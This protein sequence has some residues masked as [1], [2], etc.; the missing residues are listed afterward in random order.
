MYTHMYIPVG[1]QTCWS[2]GSA[3]FCDIMR[4]ILVIP[5]RHFGTTYRSHLEGSMILGFLTLEACTKPIGSASAIVEP[6]LQYMIFIV[7]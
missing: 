5:Y 6:V 1:T 7:K 2:L 4:R 3:L